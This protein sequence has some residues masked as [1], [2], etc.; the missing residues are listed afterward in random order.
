MKQLTESQWH[1]VAGAFEL[2]IENGSIVGIIE[3]GQEIRF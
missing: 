2:I 1:Q 3:N